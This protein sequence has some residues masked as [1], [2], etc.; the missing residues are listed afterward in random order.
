MKTKSMEVKNNK[1]YM[2]SYSLEELEK[3]YGTPLYVYDE[4]GLVDKI[5]RYKNSFKSD[6]YDC[7]VVYASK[8]FICPRLC[9]ILRQNNVYIDAISAGD[10][11]LLKKSN[12]PMEMVVLHGNNKSYQELTEA[13][14]SNIGYIVVDNYHELKLVKEISENHKTNVRILIRINPGIEGHTHAYIETSLLDSKFGESIYDKELQ[15]KMFTLIKDSKYIQFDGFHAHIGSQITNGDC[16]IALQK[17]LIS[18]MKEVKEKYGFEFKTLNVGGGFGIKY[19]DEDEELDIESLLPKLIESID[20]ELK[21]A[22]ISVNN[23]MIEPGRSI[24]GDS[25]VTIYTCGG[26]KRT[27]A[28]VEYIF[29]DGGMPD[30]IRPALYDAKYTIKNASRYTASEY[31]KY[32]ISGK[33]C[34]SGDIIAKGVELP[35]AEVG[36]T[37]VAFTTGA[38]CYSMSMNYNELTKPGVI[39]VNGDK[40]TE[41]VKRQT[42]EDML[43]CHVFSDDVKIFDTHSDML[44]ALDRK[45]KAGVENHFEDYHVKQLKGSV[46]AGGLWTMYS[47]DDFDLVEGLKN[48]LKQIDMSKLPGFKVILGLEGLRNLKTV[49]DLDEIYEMGFRHAMVTWNEANHFATGARPGANVDPNRGITEEGK[50]LY[51]RMQ[52]LGMIIDLA[53]LNEKSFYEALEIVDKNIIYSHGLCKAL[54]N[55]PRNLTDEQMIALKK[56]DGLFGLTLANNFVSPNKSEQDLEHF[57]DH[58]DYAVKFMSI[59]NICFG[60][61][62]MDYLSEFPNSNIVDV[63]DATKAYRIIDGMRRRGYS[64]EDIKKVCYQNFYERYKDKI[65]YGK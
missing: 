45:L 61:D 31:K 63:P 4:I 24:V 36:D 3:K 29:I 33:C 50:R 14:C 26:V 53:H 2:G 41:V 34:E 40:V 39:F 13:V 54:C 28:N 1:L 32:N 37:I 18:F 38:Y 46:I 10:L 15:D 27:Y 49:E 62:F 57:L 59:D 43:S 22:G 25:C 55:H 42:P 19:L 48:A 16:Y 56:V 7:K 47:P 44:Y 64:E 60:F 52:E 9:S 58:L 20:K 6:K 12:Y 17:K 21:D 11:Y 35:V 23:L 51:K 8:A 5:N 30:N 65:V